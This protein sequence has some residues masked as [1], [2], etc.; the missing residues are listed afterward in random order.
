M[1]NDEV[2]WMCCFCGETVEE[3]GI[4][5]CF[6]TIYEP[7]DPTDPKRGSQQFYSHVS[8]LQ[9]RMHPDVAKLAN[10]LDPEW[11]EFIRQDDE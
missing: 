9:S 10:A 6:L 1:S 4:D 11:E 7:E 5:P 8:C 2:K 3:Q